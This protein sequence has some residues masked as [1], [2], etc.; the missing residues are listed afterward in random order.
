[1]GTISQFD[2]KRIFLPIRIPCHG[3]GR[4]SILNCFKIVKIKQNL[5]IR[6]KSWPINANYYLQ[7]FSI[8]R[9][10]LNPFHNL[11]RLGSLPPNRIWYFIQDRDT[12][13][14]VLNEHS[15]QI[16]HLTILGS[17]TFHDTLRPGS[18]NVNVE[19]KGD[20]LIRIFLTSYYSI[21]KTPKGFSVL[22]HAC[23]TEYNLQLREVRG[24][25]VRNLYNHFLTD[26][27]K[28][29]VLTSIR[30]VTNMSPTVIDYRIVPTVVLITEIASV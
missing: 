11:N 30:I 16:K 14:I 15:W 20:E 6:V 21:V 19:L 1:M 28:P 24:I 23:N 18:Q 5:D 9:S 3:E 4:W 17:K 10:N 22:M 12:K 25:I 27:D 13:S 8:V 7:L 26:F 29:A 2:K